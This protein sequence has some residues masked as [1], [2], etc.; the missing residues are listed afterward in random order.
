MTAKFHIADDQSTMVRAMMAERR[1]R[2]L[3]N[4]CER[5]PLGWDRPKTLTPCPSPMKT[6]AKR[7][8][9]HLRYGPGHCE[10]VKP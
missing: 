5:A 1:R 4:D 3:Y 10:R 8:Y 7:I 6:A 9:H 2:A